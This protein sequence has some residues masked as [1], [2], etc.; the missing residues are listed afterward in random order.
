MN[1]IFDKTI[2]LFNS[3]KCEHKYSVFK[4][5]KF[6]KEIIL[7]YYIDDW[8]SSWI[9]DKDTFEKFPKKY[10]VMSGGWYGDK[11]RW[12]T[13]KRIVKEVRCK[14]FKG[15]S[16]QSYEGENSI[17]FAK[18]ILSTNI[19]VKVLSKKLGVLKFKCDSVS[20]TDHYQLFAFD[21]EMNKFV[22]A[23]HLFPGGLTFIGKL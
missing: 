15:F 8:S 23:T 1:K 3:H 10:L 5:T 6:N 14:G 22:D 12:R 19:D 21:I 7:R 2:G 20:K 16:E 13:S 17:I 9:E 18:R 4:V 11:G